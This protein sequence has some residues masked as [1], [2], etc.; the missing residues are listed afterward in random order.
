MRVLS[1]RL[2]ENKYGFMDALL[3]VAALMIIRPAWY[4]ISMNMRFYQ[5]EV[6][7]GD[8]VIRSRIRV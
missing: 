7:V 8:K 5:N 4:L 2:L 1:W 3:V 6:K